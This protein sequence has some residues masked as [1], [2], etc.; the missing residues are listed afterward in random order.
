MRT[1]RTTRVPKETAMKTSIIRAALAAS[2][3]TTAV[4][5]TSD[6]RAGVSNPDYYYI[7]ISAGEIRKVGGPRLGTTGQLEGDI[8]SDA[9][10]TYNASSFIVGT[11]G[12]PALT[13]TYIVGASGTSGTVDPATQL[14]SLTLNMRIKF[15][16]STPAPG[17]SV[18]TSCQTAFFSVTVSTSKSSTQ[19]STLAMSPLVGTF[20][21]VAEDFVIPQ[22]TAGNCGGA[23]NAN[24]I[25]STFNFGAAPG[26]VAIALAGSITNPSIPQP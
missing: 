2:A 24:A 15:G 16:G 21:G 14:V 7:D 13:A 6:A 8:A 20:Q 9:S 11:T 25:N 23:T 18:G 26:G 1:K 12:L 22:V 17:G 4:L 5:T 10:F 19:F 3:I